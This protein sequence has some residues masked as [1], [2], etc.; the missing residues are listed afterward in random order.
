VFHASEVIGRAVTRLEAVLQDGV[1]RGEVRPIDVRTA[2]RVVLAALITYAVWF[3]SPGVY[4][5][6][7]GADRH[8]AKEAVIDLL[9]GAA[10]GAA[11]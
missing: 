8:R 6:V 3:A 7:T 10:G 1:R 2:A 4:A 11:A 5:E 9:V